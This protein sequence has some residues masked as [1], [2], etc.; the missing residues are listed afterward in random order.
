M[1]M[2]KAK[3]EKTDLSVNLDVLASRAVHMV[4]PKTYLPA[5]KRFFAYAPVGNR[6]EIIALA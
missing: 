2:A 5:L 3:M 6:A 4:M 1:V